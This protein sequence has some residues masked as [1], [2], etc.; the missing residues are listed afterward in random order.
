MPF[1]RIETNRELSEVM[2]A[3][4]SR[5]TSARI[6]ELLGKPETY[7]MVSLLA[8]QPLIFAGNDD[9]AAFVTLQSIDLPPDRCA[10]FSAVLCDF[11]ERELDIPEDRIYIDFRNAARGQF[12]WNGGTF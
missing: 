6:A 8:R 12:G 10:E 1:I 9:P 5:A 11:M 7:V 4:K 2:V 3:E